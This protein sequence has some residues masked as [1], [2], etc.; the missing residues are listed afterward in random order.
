MVEILEPIE[1]EALT[2]VTIDNL[3]IWDVHPDYSGPEAGNYYR[4]NMAG[5]KLPDN[6]TMETGGRDP[7]KKQWQE[8]ITIPD[9]PAGEWFVSLGKKDPYGGFKDLI[10]WTISAVFS[11]VSIVPPE[12]TITDTYYTLPDTEGVMWEVNGDTVAA[13]TYPV[14]PTDSDV[15]VTILAVAGEGYVFDPPAEPVTHTWKAPTGTDE[16]WAWPEEITAGGKLVARW[17]KWDTEQQQL[18]CSLYY[19]TVRA[20]VWAY[21]RGN[22]FDDHMEPAMPLQ[23]VIV[24]AAARLSYNPEYVNRWQVSQ[25]SEV[26]S[27][28]NGFNLAEQ[29][30][31]NRYRR[32]WA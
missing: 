2:T 12:P 13:G 6:A 18:E 22:G 29:A 4:M 17:L 28:F 23:R 31:L 10:H 1:V 19:D 25:E 7:E 3:A 27:V 11:E 8:T 14:T 5:S 24:S 26:M 21:T 16:N 9:I 15:T 30:I 32:R 20:Y